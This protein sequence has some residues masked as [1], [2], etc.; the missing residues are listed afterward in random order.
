[1][2]DI[3][4]LSFTG[5]LI[6]PLVP[7]LLAAACFALSCVDVILKELVLAKFSSVRFSVLHHFFLHILHSLHNFELVDTFINFVRKRDA[8]S[9]A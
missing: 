9:T 8:T 6:G 7:A 3:S 5:V 2:I 1:M 4:S